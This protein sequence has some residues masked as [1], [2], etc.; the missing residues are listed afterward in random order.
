MSDCIILTNFPF[1]KYNIEHTEVRKM[2]LSN[3]GMVAYMKE[4]LTTKPDVLF[5]SQPSGIVMIANVLLKLIL[6]HKIRIVYYDVIFQMPSG[7]PAKIIAK[8]KGFLANQADLI[9]T[10]HKDISG[11]VRHYS[12][13]EKK[14][15]HVP[16]KAN[17]AHYID[18]ITP[19]DHG[20]VVSAGVSHRD[21]DALFKAIGELGYP[22]KVIIPKSRRSLHNT[23]FTP[24]YVPQ[25]VEVVDEEL[26]QYSWNELIAKSK[27]VVIS[28]AKSALQP[29]GIS[30]CLEAMALGKAVVISKGSSVN[31]L[32]TEDEAQF[33]EPS[34]SQSLKQA[35]HEV[36]TNDGRRGQ[37]AAKGKE[38]ALSLG[39]EKSLVYRLMNQLISDNIVPNNSSLNTTPG[40]N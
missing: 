22:C 28:I 9:Y 32:I 1:D 33:F 16:F 38:Y 11:Y 37:I 3:K 12:M 34:D 10:L 40:F 29:A 14:T 27:F 30:V 35:I 21:Y 31:G 7:Y 6:R 39:D 20:Y 26:D 17:N 13:N 19:Q 23:L 8:L 5:I 18:S 4:V 36:W 15:R 24:E 2:H 25:N